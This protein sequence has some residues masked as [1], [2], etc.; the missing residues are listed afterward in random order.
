MRRKKPRPR[1][2]THCCVRRNPSLGG[3]WSWQHTLRIWLQ[4]LPELLKELQSLSFQVPSHVSPPQS[5]PQA[6]QTTGGLTSQFRKVGVRA[7]AIDWQNNKRHQQASAISIDLSTESGES[8]FSSK[9][10]RKTGQAISMRR[11]CLVLHPWRAKNLC[12]HIYICFAS[13]SS[14]P[15]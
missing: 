3:A 11:R 5:V 14:P 2:P 8:T 1:W 15:I 6:L 9:R 10:L 13:L 4:A 7:V 12:Q